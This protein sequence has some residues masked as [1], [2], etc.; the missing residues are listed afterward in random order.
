M[1][2]DKPLKRYKKLIW[3]SQNN[4][5]L[6]YRFREPK[7]LKKKCK[8]PILFFMHGAGGRGSNNN[9]Q[10]L[11]AEGFRAFS[12]QNIFSKHS[13]YILAPQVPIDKKWVDVEWNTLKHDM[14]KI[15]KTMDMAFKLL[16]EVIDTNQIDINR[17]YVLGVSMGGFGVWDALQRRP[18]FF[19]AAVP[20]CGGGDV[21]KSK[22]I[23]HVPI[24]AWHGDKDDTIHVDR[25]RNMYQTIKKYAGNIKYSE[26]K[27]RGHDVWIDVWNSKDLWSWLYRQRR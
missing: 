25:S 23:S 15:S 1:H 19:A 18:Y 17:V 4:D 10:L 27:D 26:I 20:I 11:D 21:S 3:K 14:P 9:D 6:N 24:W 2:L 16:D 12:N 8:Y 22:L 13:S 7:N 5:T